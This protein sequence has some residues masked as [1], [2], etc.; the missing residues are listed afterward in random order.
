MKKSPNSLLFDLLSTFSNKEWNSFSQFVQSPFFNQ[1][2]DLVHLLAYLRGCILDLKQFP[3][4]KGIAKHIFKNVAIEDVRIRV[5]MS[6]LYQLAEEFLWYEKKKKNS[7]EKKYQL[8]QIYYNRKLERHAIR[9]QRKLEKQMEATR[10]QDASYFQ[11]CYQFQN[12][13]LQQATQEKRTTALEAQEVSDSLDTAFIAEKLR[14]TCLILSHQN[15]Y[16]TTYDFGF[17]PTLLLYIEQ[18]KLLQIPAIAIY[19][20][21]YFLMTQPDDD[22]NF[23]KLKSTILAEGHR[24]PDGELRDI[25]L[26]T[27]NFCI[28]KYN[29]GSDLHGIELYE[30][31]KE[32]LEKGFLFSKGQLSPF[33]YRNITTMALIAKEYEWAIYFLEH[34]KRFL[35]KKHRQDAYAFN[36]ARLLYEQNAFDEA[37]ILLQKADYKDLL[38]TLS[39]K[40]VQ[41]KIYYELAEDE[42]LDAHIE[43]MQIYVR[44][45]RIM[46]YHKE[47]YKNFLRFAKKILELPY[48]EKVARKNIETAIHDTSTLAERTWLLK[49]LKE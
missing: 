30:L 37:L 7:L 33:T 48:Y 13:S 20:Y 25:Y 18:K 22:A 21:S 46:S 15:V 2:E 44:R 3:T 41:L 45:K 47:A 9:T 17:L 32:G 5:L 42:L 28:R 40:T 38:M 4:K 35:D 34:Y 49:I 29:T 1:Q 6:Q 31:Y 19:Y 39:A 12:T 27:I 8:L 24:F 43:A 14:Q 23:L 10:I 16:N 11:A 36:K 26:I